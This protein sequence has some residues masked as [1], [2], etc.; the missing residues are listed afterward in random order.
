MKDSEQQEARTSRDND[1]CPECGCIGRFL[2]DVAEGG[3]AVG[4]GA[5]TYVEVYECRAENCDNE[6]RTV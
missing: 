2:G 6:W 5:P 3:P 1:I 4:R